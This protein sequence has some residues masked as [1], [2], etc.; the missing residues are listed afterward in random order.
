MSYILILSLLIH[1]HNIYST[2]D[3][4][5]LDASDEEDTIRETPMDQRDLPATFSRNL[6]DCLGII[7]HNN[8]G[9]ETINLSENQNINNSIHD[10]QLLKRRLHVG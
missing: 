6:G 8:I 5:L 2:D 1:T 4:G 7:G 9:S 3:K 10:I